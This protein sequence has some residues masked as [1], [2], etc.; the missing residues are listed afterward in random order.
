MRNHDY[1]IFDNHPC[2]KLD[3]MNIKIK[4]YDV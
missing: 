2:K 1:A 3:L 4:Q